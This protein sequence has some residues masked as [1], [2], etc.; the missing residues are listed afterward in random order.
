MRHYFDNTWEYTQL[1]FMLMQKC[2]VDSKIITEVKL[3]MGIGTILL[4]LKVNRTQN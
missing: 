4:N 2:L 1:G 3:I